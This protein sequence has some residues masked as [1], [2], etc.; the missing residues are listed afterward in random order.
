MFPATGIDQLTNSISLYP[1]PANDLVNVVSTNDIK[2]IEVLDYIG[3]TI[4]R[5]D[6]VNLKNTKLDVANYNSGVYFVK[7]TTT[8]GVKTIKLTVTH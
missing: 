3:K 1:N 4:Y 6:D 7:I 8:V 2:T 5:N